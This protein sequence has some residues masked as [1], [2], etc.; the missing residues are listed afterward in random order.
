LSTFGTTDPAKFQ[1][2]Q[3]EGKSNWLNWKGRVCILL[4]GTA[5]AM[6]VVEGKLK[7]PS[8][9]GEGATGAQ[10]ATFQAASA[11]Y[12]KADCSAMII[13]STNMTEET[14]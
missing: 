3:L 10:L 4:R 14:Y 11:K 2:K 1:I 8:E 5:D 13:L 6:D 12:Q 7:K 9:P